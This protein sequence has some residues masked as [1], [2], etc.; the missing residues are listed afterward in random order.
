M[1]AGGHYSITFNDIHE[2]SYIHM[3]EEDRQNHRT[4]HYTN[5]T[6]HTQHTTC[7]DN[8]KTVHFFAAP[9]LWNQ[10]N[11]ERIRTRLSL[12]LSIRPTIIMVAMVPMH[13]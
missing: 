1:R 9:L 2:G 12:F 4:E 3:Q 13:N 6:T 11:Q 5:S 10:S 8:L 7:T